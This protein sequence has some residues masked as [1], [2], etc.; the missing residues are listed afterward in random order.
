MHHVDA[1]VEVLAKATCLHQGVQVAV[2]GAD[3]AKVYIDL[4]IS[5]KPPDTTILKRTQELDLESR[6]EFSHFV[7][8][9]SAATGLFKVPLA[10]AIGTSEGPTFMAKQLCLHQGFR[11]RSTVDRH[12]RSV[13]LRV[14]QFME[15]ACQHFFAATALTGDQHSSRAR[16][17]ARGLLL[18]C[19]YGL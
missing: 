19:A 9:E 8:E 4:N 12:K 6:R 1:V 7:K 13:F 5:P 15:V 2:R 18:K 3:Q 16:S 11:N 17:D 10:K 14:G